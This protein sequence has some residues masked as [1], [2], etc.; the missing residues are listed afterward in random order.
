MS[1]YYEL[2]NVDARASTNDIK[3]AFRERAKELH[4]DKNP[5]GGKELRQQFA[6]LAE[7]YEVRRLRA[8]P[9]THAC[10]RACV[11]C[12]LTIASLP[13]GDGMSLWSLD[14]SIIFVSAPVY[15]C[16]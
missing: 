14:L 2:L 12:S 11:T 6:E 1:N 10:R 16:H 8:V 7:A 9:S 4:P 5:S 15:N 3:K 13:T